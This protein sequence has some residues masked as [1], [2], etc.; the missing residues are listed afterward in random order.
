MFLKEKITHFKINFNQQNYNP[1]ER[2]EIIGGV[3]AIDVDASS[4]VRFLV[5][6]IK[7]FINLRKCSG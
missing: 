4:V 2:L 6:R 1:S 5:V 7:V 3:V